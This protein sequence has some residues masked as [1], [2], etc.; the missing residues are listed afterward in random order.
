MF[1]RRSIS[2][3]FIQKPT[4]RK[5]LKFCEFGKA[6]WRI[7]VVWELGLTHG[8]YIVCFSLACRCLQRWLSKSTVLVERVHWPLTEIS[9]IPGR[10]EMREVG[11]CRFVGHS[12][13]CGWVIFPKAILMSRRSWRKP[14]NVARQKER[15][16]ALMEQCAVWFR[17]SIPRY[18]WW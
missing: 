4:S 6:A 17:L 15:S 13:V 11:S 3:H 9:V 10:D 16:V 14:L 12:Q 2:E 8:G 18:L 7:G 1:G 5:V